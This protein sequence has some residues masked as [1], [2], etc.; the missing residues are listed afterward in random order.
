MP[1]VADAAKEYTSV[2]IRTVDSDVVIL[3][4]YVFAQLRASLTR[5][6]VAFGIGKN[7]RMISAHGIYAALGEEKSLALPMFH[8]FTGCDTV[9]SFSG[10]GKKNSMGDMECVS[11]GNRCL[12][13]TYETTST[14]RCGNCYDSVGEVCCPTL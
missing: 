1:H 10:R 14:V 13:I 2:T 6:W 11:R 9:S 5:L 4:V 12:P 8:A 7:Y 3:A